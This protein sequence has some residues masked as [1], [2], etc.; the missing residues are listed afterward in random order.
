MPLYYLMISAASWAALFDLAI[1]PFH[2]AKTEHGR[3]RAP[4]DQEPFAPLTETQGPK[5]SW[6]TWT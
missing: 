4:K 5:F 1:R 3:R 6:P 2:W